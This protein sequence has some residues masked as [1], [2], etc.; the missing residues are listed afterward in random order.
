MARLKRVRWFK[1]YPALLFAGCHTLLTGSPMPLWSVERL[2]DPQEV[3]AITETHLRL[4]GGTEVTLPFIKTIPKDNSLLREAVRAGVEIDEGGE[5]FGLLWVDRFC[6]NDPFVSRKRRINLTE[7]A[8]ALN[9]Q[10]I[11][12][13]KVPPAKV[14]WLQKVGLI[15]ISQTR[16]DHREGHLGGMDI[17]DL[18]MVRRQLIESQLAVDDADSS[19]PDAFTD[20]RK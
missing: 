13:S 2:N 5:V 15:S 19:M 9:P 8:G 4:K 1:L 17:F 12:D 6:G 10:G 16:R 14:D 3:E 11:D 20:D 18:R 7:L